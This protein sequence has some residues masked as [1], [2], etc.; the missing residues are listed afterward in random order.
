[1]QPAAALPRRAVPRRGVTLR[2]AWIIG[3]LVANT[4]VVVA[5]WLGN[6]AVDRLARPVGLATGAGQLTGLLGAWT[7]LVGV[8]LAARVPWI[9]HV[10]GSDRLRAW[11]RWTGFLCVWLLLAHLLLTTLGLVL[12]GFGEPVDEVL[13]LW[14]SWEVLL[15]LVGLALMALVALTSMA[16]ARRRLAYETWYGLHLYAY[17]GIALAFVHQ[18]TMGTDLVA[19]PLALG[20]WVSLYLVVMGLLIAYRIVAPLRLTRRHRPRIAAVT[21]EA[22]GVVSIL[23]SGRDLAALH[24]RAGQFFNLRF[25]RGGGWWRHHPFSIS[26]MPDGHTLRFTIKD[27]GDDTHRMQTMPVG[28]P[29]FLEGPYGS[30]TVDRVHGRRVVLLAGG[31]GVAP[32]CALLQELPPEVRVSVLVRA[33]RPADLILRD[34]LERIAADR[35]ADLHLLLGRRGDP[36]LPVDPLDAAQLLRLVPDLA[37]AEVLVCGSPGF[38][39]RVLGSLRTVGVPR[40]RIHAERFGG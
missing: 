7:A 13:G 38:T 36:E 30:L 4:A 8:L 28:T 34:D 25:L 6:G 23:L 35:G 17:L 5:L 3:A 32:M 10:T 20:Y 9:D 18:V 1:M 19:D 31:V 40:A 14:T 37:V 22:D 39:D 15:A 16:A 27:L 33:S 29:V 24:V 26:A 21:P 2:P 11:H 12:A